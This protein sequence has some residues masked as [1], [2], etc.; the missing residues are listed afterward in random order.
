[1]RVQGSSAGVTE[2]GIRVPATAQPGD[3]VPLT[4]QMMLPDGRVVASRPVT[5]AIETVRP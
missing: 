1:V 4:V 3:A 2:V 5:I